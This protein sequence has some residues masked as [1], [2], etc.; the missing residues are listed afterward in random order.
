MEHSPHSDD[1][2]CRL[3]D[4]NPVIDAA[5]AALRHIGCTSRRDAA[6][7]LPT[8]RHYPELSERE[9]SAILARFPAV[10]S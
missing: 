7:R 8:W 9:I 6:R 2:L 3:Y 5:E 4:G 10:S 1:D